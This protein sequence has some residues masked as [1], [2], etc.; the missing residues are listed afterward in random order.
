VANNEIK[1]KSGAVGLLQHPAMKRSSCH[2]CEAKK[3]GCKIG[4]RHLNRKLHN[5]CLKSFLFSSY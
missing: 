2:L 3:Q 4:S 5:I 1:L